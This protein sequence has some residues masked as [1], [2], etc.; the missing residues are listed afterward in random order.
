MLALRCCGK[1]LPVTAVVQADGADARRIGVVDG[2]DALAELALEDWTPVHRAAIVV[3]DD[4]I[5]CFVSTGTV[6]KASALVAKE[7]LVADLH[8]E[9]CVVVR[10]PFDLLSRQ[11]RHYG[12]C[13]HR[14]GGGERH[15]VRRRMFIVRPRATTEVI[16]A[17]TTH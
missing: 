13:F 6:D 10:H 1:W 4:A 14:R 17:V 9:F 15:P 8:A 16:H 3:L 2:V 7:D 12:C 5:Y 11:D